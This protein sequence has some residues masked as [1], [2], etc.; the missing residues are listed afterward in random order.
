MA[1]TTLDL[2]PQNTYM[3]R[4][5]RYINTVAEAFGLDI[6]IPFSAFKMSFMAL[7][8]ML[9][10]PSN[11]VIQVYFN[12]TDTFLFQSLS[13]ATIDTPLSLPSAAVP[14]I[15]NLSVSL[16]NEGSLNIVGQLI[17]TVMSK[18]L[19]IPIAYPTTTRQSI[20]SSSN[21][22]YVLQLTRGFGQRILA[23]LTAPF[24]NVALTGSCIHGRG[25][26]TFVNDFIN[27]V[28][29]K[30]PSGY[31]IT[32]SQDYKINIKETSNKS[33]LQTLGEFANSEWLLLDSFV[34]DVPFCEVDQ[35]VISGLDVSGQSSSWQVQATVNPATSYSWVTLVIGQKI[36]SISNQ[37]SVVV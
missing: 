2:G 37:S 7:D 22:S 27:N 33:S 23:I 36:L 21:H 4:R 15:S 3:G 8:R 31:D 6:S 28:A 16:C 29:L 12:S 32:K 30:F 5:Q 14:T 17:S 20:A 10:F 25:N 24:S 18:G 34:G 11:L 26:L 13:S 1:G 35:T 19:S 9:Y